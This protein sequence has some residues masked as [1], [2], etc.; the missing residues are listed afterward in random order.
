MSGFA[1]FLIFLSSFV[2]PKSYWK[3]EKFDYMLSIGIIIFLILWS[4][5]QN[6]FVAIIFSL[7]ADALASIPTL[8]KAYYFPETETIW[9]FLMGFINIEMVFPI[10]LIF[11]CLIFIF[12]L[13]KEII[14]KFKKNFFKGII[15]ISD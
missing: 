3:L 7:V 11:T 14:H 12:F 1:P 2:N 10:Y 5:S 6:V 9:P 8:K 4:I 13:R 15:I